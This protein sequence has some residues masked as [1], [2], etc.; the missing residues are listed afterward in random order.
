MFEF[1]VEDMLSNRTIQKW[2]KKKIDGDWSI[3][4]LQRES[5]HEMTDLVEKI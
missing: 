5:R 4:D 1:Y 3:L 2:T